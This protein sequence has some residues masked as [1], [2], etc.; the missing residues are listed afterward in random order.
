MAG[1]VPTP[2]SKPITPAPRVDW[3][4]AGRSPVTAAVASRS[5]RVTSAIV[6]AASLSLLIVAWILRPSPDGL[7]THQQLGLPPCGWIVAADMPCPTCGM[8]TSFSHA[9]NGDLVSSFVAQPFGML[10]AL[11]TA[12]VAVVGGYTAL[13]G[14]MLAPFLAGMITPR[15]GW[16]AVALLIA[17]WIWKIVD[18]R[19]LL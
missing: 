11:S 14:S 1:T 8:T 19:G 10:L 16:I 4:A 7:G 3:A 6:S 17:A 18:H 13:T 5:V 9:A 2:D 12:V 15:V